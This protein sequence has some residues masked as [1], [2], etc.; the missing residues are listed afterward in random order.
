MEAALILED[1]EILDEPRSDLSGAQDH[2]DSDGETADL[3]LCMEGASHGEEVPPASEIG[4]DDDGSFRF[5]REATARHLIERFPKLRLAGSWREFREDALPHQIGDSIIGL[6]GALDAAEEG[7]L[8]EA[9]PAELRPHD[10]AE[11]RSI[12]VALRDLGEGE[13]CPMA[14]ELMGQGAADPP[15]DEGVIGVLED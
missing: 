13:A 5:I 12:D 6:G 7:F 4:G 3:R 11:L 8:Q 10:E 2:G 14:D 15:E 9:V 1:V